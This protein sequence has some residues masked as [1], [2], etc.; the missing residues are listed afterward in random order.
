MKALLLSLKIFLIILGLVGIS[1]F[2]FSPLGGII[3]LLIVFTLF[4][5]LTIAGKRRKK[6]ERLPVLTENAEVI[7]KHVQVAGSYLL[8]NTYYYITFKLTNNVRK[9]LLIPTQL[10]GTILEGEVGLLS[11]KE[12]GKIIKFIDFRKN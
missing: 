9:A 10:Y 12:Q 6:I 11:Y 7:S 4:I 5:S 2:S 1:F 3:I 8:T